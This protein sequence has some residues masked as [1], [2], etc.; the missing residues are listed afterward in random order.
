MHSTVCEWM[1][2][3]RDVIML[4]DQENKHFLRIVCY[5][6]LYVAAVSKTHLARGRNLKVML[7]KLSQGTDS[8]SVSKRC[9]FI[10]RRND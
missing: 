4:F 10:Q 6:H 3:I 2:K 7:I 9:L 5:F 1:L 8:M